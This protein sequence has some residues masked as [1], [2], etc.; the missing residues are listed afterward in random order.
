MKKIFYSSPIKWLILALAG[1]SIMGVE[2]HYYLLKKMPFWDTVINFAIGMTIAV[3]LI[4]ATF[5]I[6]A[7]KESQLRKLQEKCQEDRDFF[8]KLIEIANAL[9]MTVDITG[10]VTFINKKGAQILG[11]KREE[12][13]GR[14]WFENFL[15]EEE[16]QKTYKVF[17]KIKRGEFPLH[18]V[19]PI[20]KKDNTQKILSWDNTVLVDENNKVTGL[21]SIAQDI[22]E[23]KLMEEKL[24]TSSLTDYL[25]GLHNTRY[26][27]QRL[28]TEKQRNQRYKD[29]FSLLYIDIDNFKHCNDVYGHRVGDQVLQEF[30][31]ILKNELRKVD[32][33]FRYGG[34]EFIILLPRTEKKG[35]KKQAERIR[36]KIE[37]N[38]FPEY[39]IT[40]S[41]GVAQYR[42]GKDVVEEADKAMYE[43]KRQGKNK[44]YSK[45]SIN[46]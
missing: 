40:V 21:L 10:K 15:P 28:N 12:V 35:A 19:N 43:A 31:K 7:K 16:K 1:I 27:Y 36:K 5:R 8:N 24:R 6:V 29:P 2:Y 46:S 32:S 18:H 11:Y 34:E 4:E 39:R 23:M 42:K 9:V 44:V 26:F 25:T 45:N 22:T 41:I 3:V 30:S 33:A 37:D 17:K 20:K 13:I 38:L 14:N